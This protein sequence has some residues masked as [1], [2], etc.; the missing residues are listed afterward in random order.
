MLNEQKARYYHNVLNIPGVSP[1]SSQGFNVGQ[2]FSFNIKSGN[3]LRRHSASI[4]RHKK[5]A[6][7]KNSTTLE[8]EE[9]A[10][11]SD[12]QF[13]LGEE[14]EE[15]GDYELEAPGG[16]DDEDTDQ[17][18]WCLCK[19]KSYGNMICCDNQQVGFYT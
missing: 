12:E 15:Y 18:I 2:Q 1:L 13:E 17:Q 11:R 14:T 10:S 16:G 19:T 6:P 9:T 3:N 8:E 7:K 5:Q 4:M